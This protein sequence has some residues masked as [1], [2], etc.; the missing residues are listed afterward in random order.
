MIASDNIKVTL[1]EN[2]NDSNY[3]TM[4]SLMLFLQLTV[5]MALSGN[6]WFKSRLLINPGLTSATTASSAQDCINQC[7]ATSGCSAVSYQGGSG[8]CVKSLCG[9]LHMVNNNGWNTYVLS[10]SKLNKL[11]AE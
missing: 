11:I 9:N 4:K 6:R 2:E 10:K 8:G 1:Q 3:E 5:A 7:A